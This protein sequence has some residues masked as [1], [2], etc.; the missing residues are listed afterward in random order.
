MFDNFPSL[1][2]DFEDERAGPVARIW[3]WLVHD[4]RPPVQRIEVEHKTAPRFW[5]V[6]RMCGSAEKA[7]TLF[8][9]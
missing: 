5:L 2:P 1:P 4:N 6:T 7:D 3:H 9:L 8:S